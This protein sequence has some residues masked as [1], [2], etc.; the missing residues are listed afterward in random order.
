MP[1]SIITAMPPSSAITTALLGWYDRHRRDLPWRA[2]GSAIPDPYGV[3]LSEV[4]LQQTTVTAVKSYYAR[5]LALWPDVTALAEAPRDKVLKEW[6]GL[7]YYARARN[8]HDCAKAVVEQH[9]G[10]FPST[11]AELRGLPGIG[12]YT[13]AA[14]AAIAFGK[15]ATVVDGNVERVMTRLYAVEIPLPAARPAIR[16]LVAALVPPDRP[17]DFAQA[18]MD[19]GATLCTPKSPACA[20][21]P[22]G[23]ACR[24]RAAGT[25]TLYPKK[26]P[27]KALPQR[28]GAM[29]IVAR[30]DGAVLVRTRPSKGMLGGMTEFLASDWS[31]EPM[32]GSGLPVVLS[33]VVKRGHI[34]HVFTHFALRLAVCTGRLG[35]DLAPEGYRWVS[36]DAL[37]QE[38][39]PAVFAK[40]WEAA[41]R[42]SSDVVPLDDAAGFSLVGLE[43]SDQQGARKRKHRQA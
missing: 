20:I 5:F 8:L 9:A 40:V 17:G 33:D 35:D 22:I 10:R 31:D 19:F 38:P 28:F 25:Q 34:D 43:R 41:R 18:T 23:D 26:L 14:V 24:A 3:W 7:G 39:I 1:D 32:D 6:A 42:R 16:R 4:M 13:A 29:A 37:A 15:D 27:K 21:C 11:E 12:D 36:A 30:T 2:K